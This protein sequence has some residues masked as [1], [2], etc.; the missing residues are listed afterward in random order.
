MITAGRARWGHSPDTPLSRPD[1]GRPVFGGP[2]QTVLGALISHEP[3]DFSAV[4]EGRVSSRRQN[5][6]MV[7][8]NDGIK[9]LGVYS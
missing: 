4:N 7:V 3:K 2:Y 9:P 6:F 5:T 8:S 1:P